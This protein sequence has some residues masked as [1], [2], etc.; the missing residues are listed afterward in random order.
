MLVAR[1]CFALLLLSLP[2]VIMEQNLEQQ[3]K[4]AGIMEE[5]LAAM[6]LGEGDS[7]SPSASASPSPTPPPTPPHQHQQLY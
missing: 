1:C 2:E 6:E 3:L 4:E 7:R 5:E